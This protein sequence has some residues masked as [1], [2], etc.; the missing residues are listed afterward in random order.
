MDLFC[1]RLETMTGSFGIGNEPS[2]FITAGNLAARL[3][4][5]QEGLLHGIS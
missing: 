4:A 3:L 1:S 2:G 5:S